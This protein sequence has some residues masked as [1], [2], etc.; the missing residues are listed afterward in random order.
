MQVQFIQLAQWMSGL[1]ASIIAG[2]SIL[3]PNITFQTSDDAAQQP[4]KKQ[5]RIV[6]RIETNGKLGEDLDE[7]LK[8]HNV[9]VDDSAGIQTFSFSDDSSGTEI[10][11]IDQDKLQG[12]AMTYFMADSLVKFRTFVGDSLVRMYY[13]RFDSLIGDRNVYFKRFDK[14][15]RKLW[16]P[17]PDS[18]RKDWKFNFKRFEG[19]LDSAMRNFKFDFKMDSAV[20]F[21]KFDFKELDSE[22]KN[23]DRE[24]KNLDREMKNLDSELENLEIE[25]DED[26]KIIAPNG[27]KHSEN[28]IIRTLPNRKRVEIV[29]GAPNGKD[30][31]T[32][33]FMLRSNCGDSLKMCRERI[34]L[35]GNMPVP[36]DAPLPPAIGVL[37][38]PHIAIAPF[39][40]TSD[41][42]VVIIK[43]KGVKKEKKEKEKTPDKMLATEEEPID[44]GRYIPQ[45]YTEANPWNVTI[46]PNPSNGVMNLSCNLPSNDV[47]VTLGVYDLQGNRVFLKEGI[48]PVE[49]QNMPLDL[50]GAATGTYLVQISQGDRAFTTKFEIQK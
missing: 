10:I 39:P 1:A 12:N 6:R 13:P 21:Y 19:N 18:L 35:H 7:L 5:Q 2:S 17:H 20:N 15:F 46:S 50:S 9:Q 27:E 14:E 41:A 11:I 32:R 38:E 36:P 42:K 33:V 48:S 49:F 4:K 25:I 26:V 47:P 3:M 29:H 45:D 8:K 16:R 23:L 44:R 22:M 34:I 24:M 40:A 31:K 43:K 30:G 28:V 37:P